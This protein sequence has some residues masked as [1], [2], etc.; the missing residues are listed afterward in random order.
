MF[1]AKTP[2]GWRV[3]QPN[4]S[5]MIF[6]PIHDICLFILDRSLIHALSEQ[7]K[8]WGPKGLLIIYRHL[9]RQHQRQRTVE[10]RLDH[11]WLYMFGSN[12]LERDH[13]YYGAR[14]CSGP[15]WLSLRGWEVRKPLA[16]RYAII[17]DRES[18]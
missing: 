4:E 2:L 9:R 5:S 15:D 11:P 7:P 6:F 3:F 1:I 8:S 12:G 10:A 13:G 14:Q 17:A 16:I 18:F